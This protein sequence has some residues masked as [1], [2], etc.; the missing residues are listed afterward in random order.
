MITWMMIIGDTPY[1]VDRNVATRAAWRR[2]QICST[3]L[4]WDKPFNADFRS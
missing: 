4:L 3:P 2:R 1:M